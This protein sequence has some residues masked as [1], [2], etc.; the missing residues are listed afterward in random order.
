MPSQ[1]EQ[2]PAQCAAEYLS[3]TLNLFLYLSSL[4]LSLSC[5]FSWIICSLP[6]NFA[7]SSTARFLFQLLQSLHFT[8]FKINIFPT[9]K[10]DNAILAFAQAEAL[11]PSF[12]PLLCF[13]HTHISSHAL[14]IHQNLRTP[15]LPRFLGIKFF[16][17]PCS[18]RGNWST[19]LPC[20]PTMTFSSLHQGVARE[21]QSPS[22]APA[23]PWL[24]SR[25]LSDFLS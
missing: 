16:P 22:R 15:L 9:S 20:G 7:P 21:I 14:K 5:T 3:K 11:A 23:V 18:S 12:S 8:F 24:D 10:N 17:Q 13:C 19:Y 6:V 2:N 4:S 25:Y 1:V